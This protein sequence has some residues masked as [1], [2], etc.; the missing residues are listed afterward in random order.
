MYM[1]VYIYGHFYTHYS[2]KIKNNSS[3]TDIVNAHYMSGFADSLNGSTLN[4]TL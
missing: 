2:P 4:W 3:R 1:C